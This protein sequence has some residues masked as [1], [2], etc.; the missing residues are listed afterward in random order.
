M[1]KKSKILLVTAALLTLSALFSWWRASQGLAGWTEISV[2]W[3]VGAALSWISYMHNR[4][5]ESMELDNPKPP[6]NGRR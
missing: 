4:R 5:K 6:G 1:T 2:L 3:S